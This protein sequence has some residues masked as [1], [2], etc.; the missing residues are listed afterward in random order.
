M[1]VILS[2]KKC[3]NPLCDNLLDQLEDK[4]YCSSKCRQQAYRLRVKA[5]TDKPLPATVN[6]SHCRNCGKC[7]V[8]LSLNH[9]FC[10]T[11]CRVSFWQQM[12]RL[13]EAENG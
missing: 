4:K 7:F 13:A 8:K 6:L 9:E 5:A 1:E 12:K 10:G 3:R 11:S 2:Y